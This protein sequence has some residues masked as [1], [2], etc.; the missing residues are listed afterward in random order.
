[1]SPKKNAIEEHEMLKKVY[2]PVKLNNKNNYKVIVRG[3]EVEVIPI[4]KEEED[5]KTLM[6]AGFREKE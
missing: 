6:Q 5:A 4:D 1:M 3:G 2:R